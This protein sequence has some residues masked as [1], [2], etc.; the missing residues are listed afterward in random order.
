MDN[1]KIMEGMMKLRDA[2]EDFCDN[3]DLDRAD[4]AICRKKKSEKEKKDEKEE[5]REDD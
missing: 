3:M 5:K 2:I 4:E 1:K